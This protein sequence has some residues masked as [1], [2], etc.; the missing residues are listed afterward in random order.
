MHDMASPRVE[1]LLIS[2]QSACTVDF[3]AVR[4]PHT[5]NFDPNFDSAC[6]PLDPRTCCEA[7]CMCLQPMCA[8][9]PCI[10]LAMIAG[11]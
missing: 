6:A 7:S 8:G 2:L 9:Y 3:Q 10:F 4:R 1:Q 5:Q 11:Y